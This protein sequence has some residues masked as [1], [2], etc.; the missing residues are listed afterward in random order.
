MRPLV[1][2]ALA[3]AARAAPLAAQTADTTP[4]PRDVPQPEPAALDLAGA[5]CQ[6][7]ARY[8]NVRTATGAQMAPDGQSVVFLTGTTGLPQLWAARVVEGVTMAPWQLTF[9]NRVQF[10]SYSPDGRWIAYGSDRGG[11][12]RSQIFLVSPDGAVE[13]ALTPADEHFRVWGGW[14]PRGGRIAYASSERNGR[15]FDIWLLDVDAEGNAKGAP[16]MAL[17]GAGNHGIAAW[18]PDGGALVLSQGRGEADNDLFLLDLATG[19]LDTLFA[20]AKMSSYTAVQWAPDGRGFYLAT[21]HERDLAGLAFYDVAARRLQWLREPPHDVERV[22]LSHDG[23]WLA[24]SE[25]RGGTSFVTV[26]DLQRG[27]ETELTPHLPIESW[28]GVVTALSWAAREARLVV[29]LS[30]HALPGDAWVWSPTFH[31]ILTRVTESSTA[32]LHLGATGPHQ[33]QH[34][35]IDSSDGEKVY[36][37]F[38]PSYRPDGGRTPVVVTVHG[39]PTSQARPSFD[40]IRRYLLARGYAVL[41]LNFRGS[42]GYGQRFT[43]L[44]NGR[45]RPNVVHDL[46]AAAEWLKTLPEVDGERVAIMGGSYGGYLTLAALAELPGH[47]RAGVDL[48]GVANWITALE[49]ASP[50]LKNSDR[51]EYGDIDDAG[52]RAFFRQ[53]SPLTSADRIRGALMV[54]HGANDPRVPVAEADQIVRAVRARGGDVEYLRFPDEGHGIAR[55]QNRITAYQRVARFLD[56]VLAGGAPACAAR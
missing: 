46:A 19:R 32:G 50:Q 41:D 10:A 54:V 13:R 49:D 15:D 23:R 7:V 24:W 16:R 5:P 28:D 2:L 39:G 56:R 52:D 4:G 51:I 47:F 40:P 6:S 12:E 48:V 44:D 22:A 35:S 25:N 18:R 26:A 55:L 34:V 27:T 1:F 43:Q 17:R 38:Y 42:T 14:S 45:L 11:N 20:P 37:L 8:L 53:L 9:G 33:V 29:G 3:L 30:S 36:G 31:P 21:N